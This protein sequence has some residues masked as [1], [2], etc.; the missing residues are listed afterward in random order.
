MPSPVISYELESRFPGTRQ[1]VKQCAFQDREKAVA[2]MDR[3]AAL[4]YLDW[5]LLRVSRT[6]TYTRLVSP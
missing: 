1:W 4:G 5:R 6:A 3:E 2:Y